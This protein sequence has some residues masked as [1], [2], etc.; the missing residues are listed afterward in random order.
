MVNL[1]KMAEKASLDKKINKI[2]ATIAMNME[3]GRESYG[4][5]PLETQGRWDDRALY[6]CTKQRI[7][8]P[9]SLLRYNLRTSHSFIS[10]TS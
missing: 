1:R 2:S 6:S 5:A 8:V 3:L 4:L 10:A 7:V 9:L